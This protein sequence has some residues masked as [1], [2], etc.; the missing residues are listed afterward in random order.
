MTEPKDIQLTIDR[1]RLRAQLAHDALK[2]I[3]KAF[4][5]DNVSTLD[6]DYLAEMVEGLV[7]IVHERNRLLPH[8]HDPTRPPA[9]PRPW[10]PRTAERRLLQRI[11]EEIRDG[12]A[13][14]RDT[15]WASD[16]ATMLDEIAHVLD[17]D[18]SQGA[19]VVASDGVLQDWHV[20]TTDADDD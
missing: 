7:S 18:L 14:L 16:H 5:Y 6:G 3:G 10:R 15:W 12:K 9:P 4:G 17:I 1:D 8:G 20:S 11:G 19:V 13:P 2:R